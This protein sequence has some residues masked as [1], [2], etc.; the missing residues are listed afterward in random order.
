MEI[1]TG[2]EQSDPIEFKPGIREDGMMWSPYFSTPSQTADVG[3]AG[4]YILR[5]PRW[6]IGSPLAHKGHSSGSHDLAETEASA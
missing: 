3:W 1:R 6:V 5:L 4:N 2:I